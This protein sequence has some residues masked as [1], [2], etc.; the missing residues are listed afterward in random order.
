LKTWLF[1][2]RDLIASR[3]KG[4]FMMQ[5]NGKN[6]KEMAMNLG[7]RECKIN[8]KFISYFIGNSIMWVKSDS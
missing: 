4:V 2:G 1:A 5:I 8:G 7:Y 6:T 3:D